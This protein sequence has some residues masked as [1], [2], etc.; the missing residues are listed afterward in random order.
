MAMT[1]YEFSFLTPKE[2]GGQ[3]KYRRACRVIGLY[4]ATDGYGFAHCKDENGVK[5]TL[6]TTDVEYWRMAVTVK[7]DGLA[8]LEL[9]ADKFPRKREG[10]PDEWA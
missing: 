6:I 9:P 4:P 2:M 3:G 5:W 1:T 8:D 10:W 7:P